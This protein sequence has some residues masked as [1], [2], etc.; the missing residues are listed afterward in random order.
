MP[1]VG[2]QVYPGGRT[3][4]LPRSSDKRSTP[5]PGQQVYPGGRTKGLSWR[6][7][8]NRSTSGPGT[9]VCPRR[10]EHEVCPRGHGATASQ[11]GQRAREARRRR[12]PM[13]L[14]R[15]LLGRSW[16]ASFTVRRA[17]RPSAGVCGGPRGARRRGA[18]RQHGGAGPRP[19]L[20]ERKR[21]EVQRERERD[22]DTH[23]R[24]AHS[25][26]DATPSEHPPAPNPVPPL[27]HALWRGLS[28]RPCPLPLPCL[29]QPP[30]H[31]RLGAPRPAPSD[32]PAP[33]AAFTLKSPA[34]S[35]LGRLAR[36]QRRQGREP[37]HIEAGGAFGRQG[38]SPRQRRQP[39]FREA[40]SSA[41][42][43]PSCFDGLPSLALRPG[44]A[45]PRPS[46]GQ[47]G[48]RKRGTQKGRQEPGCRGFGHK[49]GGGSAAGSYRPAPSLSSPAP[50]GQRVGRARDNRSTRAPEEQVCP[51]GRA[52]GGR[53]RRRTTGPSP[54][55]AHALKPGAGGDVRHRDDRS[56]PGLGCNRSTP[57]GGRTPGLYPGCRTPGLARGLAATVVPA[58]SGARP[59][60]E[61]VRRPGQ[62]V[63]RL[64][65]RPEDQV[66]PRCAAPCEGSVQANQV[67]FGDPVYPAAGREKRAGR[68]EGEGSRAAA[69]RDPSPSCLPAAAG[70]ATRGRPRRTG[71]RRTLATGL[72]PCPKKT[73]A[74]GL[75]RAPTASPRGGGGGKTRRRRR[76]RC[77]RR[78]RGQA[79]A[80]RLGPGTRAEGSRGLASAAP[81][82]SPGEGRGRLSLARARPERAAGGTRPLVRA[83]SGPCACGCVPGPPEL[84]VPGLGPARRGAPRR[85]ALA[86]GA[87]ARPQQPGPPV[88]PG[89][90]RETGNETATEEE[91]ERRRVP[92]DHAVRDGGEAAP[93]PS[94]PPLPTT[95][96]APH[97]ARPGA[98]RAAGYREPT[99][100][101][102][103]LRYRYV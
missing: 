18:R 88:G 57:G 60:Q 79:P 7:S 10:P 41:L 14:G 23:A 17:L 25:Q 52:A 21:E 103:A 68:Q 5:A 46:P 75:P 16:A 42:A 95:S 13:R 100:A 56:S 2:Q 32:S 11:R 27:L 93:H 4:G 20:T 36:L 98:G 64:A 91:E 9:Q 99:E 58:S 30:A 19:S 37:A 89:P 71:A 96:G 66:R 35:L 102:A 70:G 15:S 22:R 47:D 54:A 86:G 29:R 69:A 73:A 84:R 74:D 12:P 67:R 72:P 61:H 3:T 82:P 51:A 78:P 49:G 24:S 97:R 77:H 53:G 65:E 55:Q 6:R 38:Q 33:P 81:L 40:F 59:R 28:P 92:H 45:R 44:P 8:D 101:P 34:R 80:P 1:A 87:R 31:R 48:R 50:G 83:R 90:P 76:R 39:L 62:Q 43:R 63:C 26:S 85:T 94:A